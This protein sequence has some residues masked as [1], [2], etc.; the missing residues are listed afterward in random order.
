MPRRKP[1]I[2]A[3]QERDVPTTSLERRCERKGLRM[4]VQRRV[5]LGVLDRAADHPSAVEIHRRAREE[6]ASISLATIYRTIAILEGAG[7]IERHMFQSDSAHYEVAH[8]GE[9]DHLIDVASGE[10]VEF[11]DAAFDRLK[12]HVAR[13]LGYT[14]V[15]CR[16]ELYAHPL[17]TSVKDS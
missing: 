17:G 4:T 5:I 6:D 10:V 2:R 12:R 1:N 14:L 13:K 15:Q 16:V 3:P 8:A 9:H 7:I 11:S